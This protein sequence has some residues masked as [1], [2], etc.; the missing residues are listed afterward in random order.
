MLD[1]VIRFAVCVIILFMTFA[2]IRVI[3]HEVNQLVSNKGVQHEAT[4]QSP[5]TANQ[6]ELGN[7]L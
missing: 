2:A 5:V 6:Q 7:P 4:F 3:S 1:S